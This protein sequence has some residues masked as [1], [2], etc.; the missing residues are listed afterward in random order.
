VRFTG[1]SRTGDGAKRQRESLR[2]FCSGGADVQ[3]EAF[4]D[5]VIGAGGIASVISMADAPAALSVASV[6]DAA[7]CQRECR[8]VLRNPFDL[9]YRCPDIH[10]A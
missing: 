10:F 7:K 6:D 8:V 2:G 9:V 3:L 5:W 1:L 4:Q